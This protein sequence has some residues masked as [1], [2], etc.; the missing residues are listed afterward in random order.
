MIGAELQAGTLRVIGD[1]TYAAQLE[2][3]LCR[4]SAASGDDES[5]AL[6]PDARS[7]PG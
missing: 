7:Y 2:I 4:P 5:A 6:I 1:A 3:W